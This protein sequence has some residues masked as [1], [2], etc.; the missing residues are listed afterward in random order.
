MYMFEKS[1]YEVY[2]YIEECG[3]KYAYYALSRRS[4]SESCVS[5][6][7]LDVVCN[8]LS[9][10]YELLLSSFIFTVSNTLLMS[11]AKVIE[12]WN[13]SVWSV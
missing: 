1:S 5:F 13:G 7:S 2:M 10:L 12:K 9:G 4:V 6:T 8:E 11:S 3:W